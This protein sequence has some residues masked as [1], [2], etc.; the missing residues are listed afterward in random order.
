MSDSEKQRLLGGE[1]S[2]GSFPYHSEISTTTVT[3][4]ESTQVDVAACGLGPAKPRKISWVGRS[5]QGS[6]FGSIAN[7]T[8]TVLGTGILTLPVALAKS[9]AVLG[10]ALL[11][12]FAVLS[13]ASVLLLVKCAEASGKFDY[14][15]LA[16]HYYGKKGLICVR[17]S[18]LF[19]LFGSCVVLIIVL[20]DLMTPLCQDLFED[21]KT[22]WWLSREFVT[23][24]FVFLI[25]PLTLSRDLSALEYTSAAAVASIVFVVIA[26]AVR[27]GQKA[28]VSSDVVMLNP[29]FNLVLCLPIQGLA[30]ACQFNVLPLYSELR[31]ED[32]PKIGRI[33]HT[34]LLGITTTLYVAF[35]LMGYFYFGPKVS[36]NLLVEF[37]SDKMMMIARLAVALVNMLKLPLIALPF[38]QVLNESLMPGKHVGKKMVVF[39]MVIF[40]GLSYLLAIL[41]QDIA[42]GFQILGSTAGMLICFILP[43]L[44]Y[45]KSS[46]IDGVIENTRFGEMWKV[47][48]YNLVVLG[49][50]V[51]LVSFTATIITW[52]DD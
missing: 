50:L 20:G 22:E 12:C 19:L 36:S 32:K 31:V 23:F 38:R 30:Y 3:T 7:L 17:A 6:V 2:Y 16:K 15:R 49:V 43:G 21:H 18:L 24:V 35:G 25:F 34:T 8:A 27:L 42:K 1:E 26:L 9:G 48:A 5:P 45:I 39:E 40:V 11:L 13:D 52:N 4:Y 29:S 41:L 28:T 47:L 14:E 33:I 44:F 46:K 10:T 37:P 51:G